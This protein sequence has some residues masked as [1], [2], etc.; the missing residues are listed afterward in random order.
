MELDAAVGA[1]TLARENLRQALAASS[2][3]Q[4]WT[5][6]ADAA[7]ALE[8]I[9]LTGLPLPP[10][11][12]EAF[13]REDLAGLLPCAIISVAKFAAVHESTSCSWNYAHG[14]ILNLHLVGWV[15]QDLAEYPAAGGRKFDNVI[16][17][18]IG[19]LEA[20]SG[21]ADGLAFRRL[22]MM[23]E[24]DRGRFDEIPTDNELIRTDL[25]LSWED[26]AQ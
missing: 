18:I 10:R 26:G 16:A 19:D 13:T 15:D 11:E 9:H 24:P 20:V 6:S 23:D 14:G 1:Y 22:D 5:G 2:T 12:Q 3:F 8:R 25:L 21:T 17:G 4:A 7:A